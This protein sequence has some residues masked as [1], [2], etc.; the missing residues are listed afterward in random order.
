MAE[1]AITAVD[2]VAQ[3][4]IGSTPYADIPLEPIHQP[5]LVGSTGTSPVRVSG[6]IALPDRSLTPEGARAPKQAA[7]G[8]VRG[9][10][11]AGDRSA[12][13][14]DGLS[15]TDI[16]DLPIGAR[17]GGGGL[18]ATVKEG[19]RA[20]FALVGRDSLESDAAAARL[21][22]AFC[23][24]GVPPFV[25]DPDILRYLHPELSSA[26]QHDPLPLLDDEVAWG[27][28]SSML[29]RIA[30]HRHDRILTTNGADWFF[31]QRP[32]PSVSVL[33][34][35]NRPAYVEAALDRVA[36][37][38]HPEVEVVL[39]LHGFEDANA[40]P[41]MADRGL[42]G[43]VHS[44]DA[45]VPL[46]VVLNTAAQRSSGQVVTKWD[47]D[48]LYGPDHLIDLCLAL[49]YSGADMVG[50]APEFIYFST[51]DTTVLRNHSGFESFSP[52]IAGGTIA[53]PRVAFDDIGGFPPLPRAVDHYIK[54]AA[55]ASGASIYRT[56]GYGFA[57]VRHQDGHTW[58]PPEGE[59]EGGIQRT[60][61]G[62]PEVAGVGAL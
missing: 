58:N 52:T 53:M 2:P 16:L 7:V 8:I 34:S 17:A 5:L 35:T 40:A 39:M 9:M 1:Q 60:W 33:L 25:S 38:H 46:G 13:W 51:D 41:A 32:L 20:T 43:H 4:M 42:S 12:V 55:L 56:H 11:T 27:A 18:A 30:W 24:A 22:L 15:N 6:P 45:A 3:A 10:E 19:R 59:L 23:C 26:L 37:Q 62:I 28:H 36:A 14:L 31:A 47:D 21:A 61:A 29:R 50:K 57:L 54:Q 49:R 48:D 44:V